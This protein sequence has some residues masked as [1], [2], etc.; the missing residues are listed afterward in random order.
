MQAQLQSSERAADDDEFAIEHE[1]VL[2]DLP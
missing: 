2:G 1:V